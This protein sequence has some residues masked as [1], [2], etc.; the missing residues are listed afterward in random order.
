VQL[1]IVDEGAVDVE[2][3]G[4]RVE[5]DWQVSRYG[6]ITTNAARPES[7]IR[8]PAFNPIMRQ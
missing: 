2:D 5:L 6:S 1:H 4:A 8:R 3:D 7:A